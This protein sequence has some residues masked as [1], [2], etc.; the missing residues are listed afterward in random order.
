MIDT[1][2]ETFAAILIIVAFYV[3]VISLFGIFLG[4]RGRR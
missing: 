1:G 3:A 2:I 4:G